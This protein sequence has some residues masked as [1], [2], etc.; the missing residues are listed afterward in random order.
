[1]YPNYF[2]MNATNMNTQTVVNSTAISNG[3]TTDYTQNQQPNNS[4]SN[5]SLSKIPQQSASAPIN[6]YNHNVSGQPSVQISY[7]P[8]TQ[9]HGP[10]TPISYQA[11]PQGQ[12]INPTPV[13]YSQTLPHV[14]A[15]QHNSNSH[16]NTNTNNNSNETPNSQP[17][18]SYTS[19]TITNAFETATNNSS[20]TINSSS[21]LNSANLVG[22]SSV[23]N[24]DE[25]MRKNLS[26]QHQQHQL[27]QQQSN[28]FSNQHN[29]VYNQYNQQQTPYPPPM[30]PTF[31]YLPQQV[32]SQPPV[33]YPALTMQAQVNNSNN[34]SQAT[35]Q[36]NPNSV[37]HQHMP[38][39]LLPPAQYYYYYAAN[40][41]QHTIASHQQI[42]PNMISTNSSQLQAINLNGKLN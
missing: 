24:L 14:P 8:P 5:I 15:S 7:Q 31:F 23:E 26:L 34:S 2:Y 40:P 21:S 38:L 10:M 22:Q 35:I 30:H 25:L 29:N 28:D 3:I 41:T 1:M 4:N 18:N 19:S 42:Q 32:G 9:N 37:A 20:D 17:S 11:H 33:A 36:V 13:F 16:N 6:I 12:F 39:P 27:H